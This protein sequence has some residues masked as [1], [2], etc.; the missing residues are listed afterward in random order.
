MNPGFVS[1]GLKLGK[2][3]LFDY[4]K[5]FGFGKKT[6]IDLNGEASGILFDINKI[7]DLELATTA[8]GQGISVTA[9]Q[10]VNA[11]SASI[12]G[13]TLYKPYIVSKVD[14]KVFDK[15]IKK[16]NIISKETS[17]L[18]KYALMSVV[19]NGSGRSAYIENYKVG[20]KTGTA[21]KVSSTGG[22]MDNNYILSFMG[23]L[24]DASSN[25]QYVVYIALDHPRGVTQYGG[26]ASAPIARSV[27]E[28]IISIYNIKED[29]SSLP[30]IYRW[31]DQVYVSVPSLIGKSKKEARKLLRS[32]YL[33]P[34]FTGDGD[35]VIDTSPSENIRVKQNSSV[36][37]LL[38]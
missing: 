27:I 12:N 33:N 4:I 20:G 22:Y 13:G 1:L 26:V 21:Q 35:T 25:N 32:V 10:Q 37:V 28:D 7:S 17:D 24:D 14:N 31:N 16:S 9:I 19:S 36:M 15:T 5:E 34:V 11:V 30:K 8:F 3:K 23:F 29:T 6:G 2:N 38:N 18:V